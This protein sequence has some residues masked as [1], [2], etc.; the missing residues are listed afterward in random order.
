M[1]VKDMVKNLI[2]LSQNGYIGHGENV[3]NL[4]ARMALQE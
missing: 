4:D 2:N 1:S 3:L